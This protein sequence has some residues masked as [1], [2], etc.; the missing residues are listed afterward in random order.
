MK[1]KLKK[2]AQKLGKDISKLLQEKQIWDHNIEVNIEL[3]RYNISFI[4]NPN[5][6]NVYYQLP[7]ELYQILHKGIE[8]M[9][10]LYNVSKPLEEFLIEEITK[11]YHIKLFIDGEKYSHETSVDLMRSNAA[12]HRRLIDCLEKEKFE[13]VGRITKMIN[14]IEKT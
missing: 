14:S 7:I 9:E 11:D 3:G 1:I 4:K 5:M 2:I 8:Q 12:L 13:E 6:V 10:A